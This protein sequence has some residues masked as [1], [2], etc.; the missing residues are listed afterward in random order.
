MKTQIFVKCV[1][2]D[3][4]IGINLVSLANRCE[5]GNVKITKCNHLKEPKNEL[6][7]AQ[8]LMHIVTPFL[9][10]DDRCSWCDYKTPPIH[11]G[12]EQNCCEECQSL[13]KRHFA[14]KPC[15]TCK[16]DFYY[17]FDYDDECSV[18][19]PALQDEYY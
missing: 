2:M 5:C 15:K 4:C 12:D 17:V 18:C 7:V 11:V 9:G 1:N 19:N 6:S 10:T 8:V 16:R 13:L 3:K 14:N